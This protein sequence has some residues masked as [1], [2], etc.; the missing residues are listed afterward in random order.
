MEQTNINRQHKD[1][2]FKAIFGAPEHKEYALSLYNAVNG[3]HYDN[4]DELTFYTIED[5][6]YMG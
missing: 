3:T 6:V 4:A 5:A 1:R 2:L